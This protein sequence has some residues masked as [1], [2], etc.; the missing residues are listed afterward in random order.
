MGLKSSI[1][2]QIIPGVKFAPYMGLKSKVEEVEKKTLKF[3]PYMGLKRL[4]VSPYS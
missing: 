1:S 3:A 2:F 4:S